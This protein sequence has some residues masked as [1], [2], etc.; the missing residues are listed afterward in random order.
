MELVRKNAVQTWREILGPMDSEAAREKNPASL[1]GRLGQ[2]DINN[3]AHGSE[4]IRCQN[5]S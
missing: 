2:D 3:V 5:R 1:R 4:N